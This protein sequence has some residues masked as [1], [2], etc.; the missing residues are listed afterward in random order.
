MIFF[1]LEN[2]TV[3][4]VCEFTGK[5]TGDVIGEVRLSTSTQ[6]RQDMA[7]QNQILTS[8]ILG[9]LGWCLVFLQVCMGFIFMPVGT[10]QTTV[11]LQGGILILKGQHMEHL[12]Q[13]W[14]NQNKPKLLKIFVVQFTLSTLS[15]QYCFPFLPLDIPNTILYN[16]WSDSDHKT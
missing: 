2:P 6:T 15:Q 14:E 11:Q 5:G 1:H 9:S 4:A 8:S 16:S 3:S 7:P 10:F 12:M 13:R